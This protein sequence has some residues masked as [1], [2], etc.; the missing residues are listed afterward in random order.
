MPKSVSDSF[1][2]HTSVISCITLALPVASPTLLSDQFFFSTF[3]EALRLL[4]LVVVLT[5][6]VALPVESTVAATSCAPTNGNVH[7]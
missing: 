7:R 5:S 2:P 3:H 6:P 4:S 1:I